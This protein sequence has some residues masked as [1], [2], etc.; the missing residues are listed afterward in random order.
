MPSTI[1][2]CP[3]Y[4]MH[5]VPECRTLVTQGGNQCALVID[6]YTPCYMEIEGNAPD[7]DRCAMKGS[8][9]AGVFAKFERHVWTPGR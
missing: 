6:S 8:D 7:L 5:A 2:A 1:K 3:F 9:R 4:G